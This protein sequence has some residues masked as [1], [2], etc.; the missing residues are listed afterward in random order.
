LG[1]LLSPH[2][3]RESEK[4]LAQLRAV[5]P[6]AEPG[7]YKVFKALAEHPA[8][9]DAIAGIKVALHAGVEPKLLAQILLNGHVW[10]NQDEVV[11]FLVDLGDV[12]KKSG[13]GNADAISEALR[14]EHVLGRYLGFLKAANKGVCGVRYELKVAAFFARKY[15]G[16]QVL[17]RRSILSWGTK[18]CS[19]MDVLVHLPG[20]AH[21]ILIEAKSTVKAAMKSGALRKLMTKIAE[22][23]NVVLEEGGAALPIKEFIFQVGEELPAAAKNK[24]EETLNT[25]ED[26]DSLIPKANRAIK[27]DILN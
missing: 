9:S 4:I 10:K 7:K 24:L 20:A 18:G 16:S 5:K 3:A 27:E 22:N 23:P 21:L 2:A 19:D 14:A 13:R 8:G 11:E 17:L 1:G 15:P 12:L 6:A 26:W 25:F